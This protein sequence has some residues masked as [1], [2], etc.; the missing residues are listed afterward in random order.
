MMRLI[1]PAF[2]FGGLRAAGLVAFRGDGEP[3]PDAEKL[4]ALRAAQM[5]HEAEVRWY[6]RDNRL[7]GEEL[8]ALRAKKGV[9][10]V[11]KIRKIS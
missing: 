2:L 7:T 9:G 6:R 11:R 3:S 5:A 10:P 4:A 1:P 8:R